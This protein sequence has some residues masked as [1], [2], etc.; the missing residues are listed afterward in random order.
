MNPK[1]PQTFRFKGF[2]LTFVLFVLYIILCVFLAI[3]VSIQGGGLGGVLTCLGIA[4]FTSLLGWIFLVGKSDIVID[5]NAISRV[6]LGKN[7][8]SIE[9]SDV[10]RIVVFP[11]RGPGVSRNVNSYNVIEKTSGK[12]KIL[13]KIYFVDQYTD[14]TELIRVMNFFIAKYNIKVE[15]KFDGRTTVTSSL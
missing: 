4:A 12:K 11:I 13:R 10:Q 5:E 7:L 1:L 9:W 8:Q 2:L 15:H 14:L 3:V 6:F